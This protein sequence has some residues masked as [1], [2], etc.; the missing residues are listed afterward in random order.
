MF[1][2]LPYYCLKLLFVKSEKSSCLRVFALVCTYVIYLLFA[3]KF[4][5]FFK[6]RD[7]RFYSFYLKTEAMMEFLGNINNIFLI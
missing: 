5:Y 2:L 6:E 1:Y 4:L 3:N 7:Y